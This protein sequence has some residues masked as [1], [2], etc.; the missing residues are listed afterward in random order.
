MFSQ[1]TH[2]HTHAPR[3]P[4][5]SLNNVHRDTLTTQVLTTQTERD[6]GGGAFLAINIFGGEIILLLQPPE[7]CQRRH[8]S[9][10][11]VTSACTVQQHVGAA[12]PFHDLRH[13]S[14][15]CDG[16]RQH[17]TGGLTRR[18]DTLSHH[19]II[20]AS[21]QPTCHKLHLH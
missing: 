15:Q 6:P 14:V 13:L 4:F 7:V 1:H 20:Y 18:C 9:S 10:S 2:T 21:A 17:P 11:Q 19:F 16:A 3:A 8:V 12:P 5:I